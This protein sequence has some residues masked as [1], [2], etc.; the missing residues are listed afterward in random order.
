MSPLREIVT[1]VA[2]HDLNLAARYADSMIALK[3]GRIHVAGGPKETL[4][5][6]M[7]S[8]VYGVRSEVY[9]DD[10]GLPVVGPKGSVKR[11]RRRR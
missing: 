7:I 1:L 10:E 3:K 6:E 8:S 2:L 11:R 4:T 5:S 9:T